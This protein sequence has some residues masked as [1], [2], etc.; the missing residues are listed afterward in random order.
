MFIALCYTDARLSDQ[1]ETVYKHM[2][3]KN[4]ADSLIYFNLGHLKLSRGKYDEAISNFEYALSLDP[5]NAHAYHNL[6]TVYFNMNDLDPAAEYAQKALEINGKMKEASSLLTIIYG[7][8]G[9]AENRNKYFH[10]AVSSGHD[11]QQL[12]HAIEYFLSRD[13]IETDSE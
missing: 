6:A 9:D 8:K 1:A 7:I 10:I 3:S 11:P 12:N 13:V 2:I 5:E 4:Y